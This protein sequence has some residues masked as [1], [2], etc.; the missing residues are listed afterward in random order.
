[1]PCPFQVYKSDPLTQLNLSDL[2][3]T[4]V[5]DGTLKRNKEDEKE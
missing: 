1:M 4:I 5:Q 2:E 3:L